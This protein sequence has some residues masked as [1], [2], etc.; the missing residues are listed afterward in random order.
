MIDAANRIRILFIK[1]KVR[2]SL[3][4]L[5]RT[6]DRDFCRISVYVTIWKGA[7]MKDNS[8]YSSPY[9][10]KGRIP[11]KSSRRILVFLNVS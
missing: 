3:G 1:M 11:L 5:F 7:N 4:K 9:E 2:S 10:F 6:K 8:T